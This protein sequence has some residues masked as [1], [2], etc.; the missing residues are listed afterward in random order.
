MLSHKSQIEHEVAS[1]DALIQ[2][3]THQIERLQPQDEGTSATPRSKAHQGS[4]KGRSLSTSDCAAS[5]RS[6]EK[7]WIISDS[8]LG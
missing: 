2:H 3:I 5:F 6:S 4:M 7:V 1:K 8:M